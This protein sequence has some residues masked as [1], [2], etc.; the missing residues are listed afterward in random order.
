MDFPLLFFPQHHDHLIWD[1]Q[2]GNLCLRG[3]DA[4]LAV[5]F[6]HIV[7]GNVSNPHI[8]TFP[9]LY[10]IEYGVQFIDFGI[11]IFIEQ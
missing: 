10:G 1:F 8:I 7:F 3:G 2:V 4:P 6:R 5:T 11:N 9:F